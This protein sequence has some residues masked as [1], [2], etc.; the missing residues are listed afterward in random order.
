MT[1]IQ[2]DQ[3]NQQFTEEV[4]NK[5]ATLKYTLMDNDKTIDFYSTF[6]PS[7]LRGQGIAE[8][9]AKAA[10]SYAA[11]N[12]LQVVASCSFVQRFIQRHAEYQKLLRD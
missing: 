12:H 6:V 2:H 3:T 7:D 1:K 11:A 10:L 5:L 4:D 9:L 8:D